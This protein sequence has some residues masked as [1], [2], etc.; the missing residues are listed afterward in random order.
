MRFADGIAAVVGTEMW[1]TRSG[2]LGPAP[3]FLFISSLPL[4]KTL[5]DRC[6]TAGKPVSEEPDGFG[7]KCGDELG[8][9]SKMDPTRGGFF[10]VILQLNGSTGQRTFLRQFSCFG[11]Q[12]RSGDLFR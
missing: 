11:A 6:C 3:L 12:K 10:R 2:L 7:G 1:G 5:C 9:L 4:A 8:F